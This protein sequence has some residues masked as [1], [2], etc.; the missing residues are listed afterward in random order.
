[1]LMCWWQFVLMCVLMCWWQFVL[2]CWHCVDDCVDDSLCWCVD[3]GL[4]WWLVLMCWWLVLM[5]WWQF[6]LMCWWQFVD[7]LVTVC[8]CVGDS[9]CWWQFVLMCWWQF[10]LICWWHC[11]DVLTIFTV[12][13]VSACIFVCFFPR[14]SQFRDM[15]KAMYCMSMWGAGG[16]GVVQ[17]QKISISRQNCFLRVN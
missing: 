1:V 13:C 5:C 12:A 2:M 17:I 8:W 7:A 4:C 9:L 10:V 3:D 16:V 6:V 15:L 14:Y 11:V